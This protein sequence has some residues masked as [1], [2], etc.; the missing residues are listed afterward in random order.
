MKDTMKLFTS[1]ALLAAAVWLGLG[2]GAERHVVGKWTTKPTEEQRAEGNPL[3]NAATGL[4]V[5]ELDIREDKTFAWT[6]VGT[7][8]EGTWTYEDDV[9]TLTVTKAAGFEMSPL[10]LDKQPL[11]GTL[12]DDKN[13]LEFK[14]EQG[15][16]T[17]A[18]TFNRV[19]G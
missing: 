15:P 5:V 13:R 9:L 18:F 2:C 4:A 10:G 19:E 16:L 12:S 3:V 14:T 11:Q 6:M 8:G 7:S 1:I 17:S